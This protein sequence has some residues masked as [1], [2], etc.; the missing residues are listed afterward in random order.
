MKRV[1]YYSWLAVLLTAPV[2][3]GQCSADSPKL[4][5][6]SLKLIF[7]PQAKTVLNVFNPKGHPVDA[8]SVSSTLQ[9]TIPFLTSWAAT[10]DYAMLRGRLVD[11]ELERWNKEASDSAG[12]SGSTSITSKGSVAS[13]FSFAVENGALTR[14]ESGTTLTFRTSP[15]NVL[16]ALRKGGWLAAGPSVP[17]YD[18]T[19]FS[20]AKRISFFVSFDASRGNSNNGGTAFTGD[21][22]QFAGWGTRYEIINKRDPRHPAYR[23]RFLDLMQKQ[24]KPAA[25]QLQL[26]AKASGPSVALKSKF[27]EITDALAASIKSH[28]SDENAILEDYKRADPKF[29]DMM[30]VLSTSTATEDQNVFKETAKA[31]EKIADLLLSEADLFNDISRSLTLA[32]E[33]NFTKQANT[34]GTLPGNMTPATGKFPDLGNINLVAAKGFRDGP[35]FTF[36][37]GFTWFQGL[38]AGSTSGSIRDF[39]TSGQLDFPLP[40][41]KQIG[42][43]TLSVAGLY[44]SLFEEPLGQQV[45]VNDVPITTKGNVGLVQGKLTVPTKNAVSIP[46]SVTWASR[47]EL[48]KESDVRGNIGITLDLDKLFAKGESK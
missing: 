8:D 38:P 13:L 12:A 44:L 6:E 40:E 43:L 35:E 4:D 33:Y 25:Q 42:K 39:R 7:A 28:P 48:I 29:Q 41:I 34:N 36:N 32:V 14:S 46:I 47:T 1:L 27:K 20:I 30:C 22:Q 31:S 17:S 9:E 16:A 11:L 37:A 3:L 45:V 18:G 26:L 5:D 23:Q 19:F 15:A 24:G 2:V 21:K 10:H